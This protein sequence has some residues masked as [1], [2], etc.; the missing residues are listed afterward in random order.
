M[1]ETDI[2]LF[3][4]AKEYASEAEFKKYN[5]PKYLLTKKRGILKYA[6]PS[7]PTKPKNDIKGIYYLY[8]DLKVIYIGHS[9]ID[10]TTA[11]ANH[12]SEGV[13]PFNSYKVYTPSSDAD[14]VVLSIYLANY[15]R[16][17]Y[18]TNICKNQLSFKIPDVAQILGVPLK[19][20]IN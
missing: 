3:N 7:T 15:Y 13:I 9:V 4:I 11:I 2:I 5:L 20:N 8:K 10:C 19:G 12:K 1:N 16:P 6:F 18:N 17:R 14:I